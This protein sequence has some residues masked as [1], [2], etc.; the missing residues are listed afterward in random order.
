MGHLCGSTCKRKQTP[1]VPCHTCGLNGGSRR[2]HASARQ[3]GAAVDMYFDGLSY[4]RVAENIEQYFGRPT[5]AVT[6]MRWVHGYADLAH[7]IVTDTK[8]PTGPEWVADE[9]VVKVG[10]RKYWL[11][12]VMDSETRFI[13]AAY[14]SPVRTARAAATAMSI[15][16][17]RA[18]NA[19]R[20]LK[21]DGLPSYG[22]GIRQAFPSHPVKHVVTEG[23]RAII[24]NNL[25]ERL[26][27]TLRD[28]DKTLRGLKARD[29][30]QTYIDGLVLHYN[31]F[32]P[33][34][35]LDGKSPARAAGADIPFDNWMDIASIR[36]TDVHHRKPSLLSTARTS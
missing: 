5:N 31:Y 1:P 14:L 7:E 4:R 2:P 34:G 30:G 11:F 25:S 15:A 9:L 16:R 28:R 27:G 3:I 10:G 35:G 12:N 20:V 13:L 24:N 29:S 22:R 19:P 26:Q 8:I 36:M 21:T 23:I 6:V 18:E 32:R 17:D 33:H